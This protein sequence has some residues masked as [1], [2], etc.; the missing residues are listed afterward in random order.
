MHLEGLLAVLQLVADRPGLP[1][2]LAGLA[3]RH[4][5]DAEGERHRRGEDEPAR[6][7]AD[8]LVDH[9]SPVGVAAGVGQRLDDGA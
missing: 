4:E 9:D 8:D 2:Q 3:H 5:A 6:L 7:H 1:R